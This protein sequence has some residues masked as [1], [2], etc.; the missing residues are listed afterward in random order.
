[1]KQ[2]QYLQSLIRSLHIM[3]QHNMTVS[4]SIM[5]LKMHCHGY[6]AKMIEQWCQRLESGHSLEQ[7]LRELDPIAK[8][9]LNVG[10]ETGKIPESLELICEHLEYIDHEIKQLKE[11]ASYPLFVIIISILIYIG[12]EYIVKPELISLTQTSSAKIP[13]KKNTE[14]FW[15]ASLIPSSFIIYKN[16]YSI[17]RIPGIGHLL[18]TYIRT[19]WLHILKMTSTH[20]I[21]LTQSFKLINKHT[22]N[23]ILKQELIWLIEQCQ[24]GHLP[25]QPKNHYSVLTASELQSLE[26]GIQTDTLSMQIEL[27]QTL[28]CHQLNYYKRQLKTWMP[29]ALSL[30]TG[31]WVGYLIYQLYQPIFNL[32]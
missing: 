11:A 27:S 2:K 17:Y 23:P 16:R 22:Q 25:P 19:I 24:C 29:A 12:F 5:S 1:M 28:N 14:L 9:L 30:L 15:I 18:R 26:L 3:T 21:T 13:L 20:N 10:V 7:T 6:E 31:T 32:L 8:I 4:Q